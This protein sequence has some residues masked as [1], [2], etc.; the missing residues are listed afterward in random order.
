LSTIEITAWR[1]TSPKYQDTAFDGAG[2]EEYGGRF[3]SVG[4]PVVYTSATLSLATLEILARVNERSRLAECVCLPVTFEERHVT[5]R[6]ASD[7]PDRW[8]AR[9]YRPASQAIGDEWVR[10]EASLVLRVPSVVVPSEHNYL[11]NPEHSG[12]EEITVGEAVPLKP[13]PRLLP[14]KD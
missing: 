10:S 8:D 13:D 5:T 2:A 6:S 4:V 9:P 11:I 12:F 7:L 14:E 1:I 3:N